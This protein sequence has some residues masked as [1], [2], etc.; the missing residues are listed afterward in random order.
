[1]V[2]ANSSTLTTILNLIFVVVGALALLFIVI[3]AFR[4]IVSGGERTAT[5]AAKNTIMYAAIGLLITI[6]ASIIVNFV[7]GK[8]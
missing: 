2:G 6:S 4:Y 3:G 5:A 7:I 1:M 8:L